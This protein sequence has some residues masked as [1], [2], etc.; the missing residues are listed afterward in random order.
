MLLVVGCHQYDIHY[1][2]QC[3]FFFPRLFI[4]IL[5]CLLQAKLFN[6]VLILL[7]LGLEEFSR[8]VLQF[9]IH[10]I[11]F[12]LNR[13]FLSQ[14]LVKILRVPFQVSELDVCS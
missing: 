2:F 13:H 7:I 9:C 1:H 6:Q 4:N 12:L 14:S 8:K 5:F 3:Q 11:I 10:F